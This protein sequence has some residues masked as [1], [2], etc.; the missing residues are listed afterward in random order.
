MTASS[1]TKEQE[2]LEEVLTRDS[3]AP[4]EAGVLE[5][6]P[7]QIIIS[8][9]PTILT[10]P[11]ISEPEVTKEVTEGEIQLRTSTHDDEQTTEDGLYYTTYGDNH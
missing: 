9:E 6:I 5:S 3:V 7:D 10:P 2:P 11:V 4:I 8:P 1:P